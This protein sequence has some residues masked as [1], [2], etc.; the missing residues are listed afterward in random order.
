MTGA[1]AATRIALIMS[2]VTL[3]VG[4]VGL[5]AIPVLNAFVTDK[6]NAYGEVP[7][8]GSGSLRLP[9]GEVTVSFPHPGDQQSERRWPAGAAA[10]HDAHPARRS[11]GSGRDRKLRQ[12]NHSQQ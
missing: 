7:V 2:I 12:H 3:V 1:K 4:V 5:I 9:A 6:Y 10:H 8:P 11:R